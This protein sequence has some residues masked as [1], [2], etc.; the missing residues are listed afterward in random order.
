M[1]NFSS[2]AFRFF[3]MLYG[4]MFCLNSSA[5]DSIQK[6]LD[7][8]LEQTVNDTY[9]P[10]IVAIVVDEEQILYEGAFCHQNV[11]QSIAMESDAIHRIYSMTKPIT[12]VAALQLIQRGEIRLDDRISDHLPDYKNKQVVDDFDPISG[13]YT[14]RAAASEITVE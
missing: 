2:W 1:I 9:I 7:A 6:R 11:N 10:G 8:Y 3:L 13:N 5:Q 14:T 12:S 4:C